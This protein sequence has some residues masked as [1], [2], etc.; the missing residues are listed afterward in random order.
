MELALFYMPAASVLL[1]RVLWCFE[2]NKNECSADN[3]RH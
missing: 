1:I 3:H 2:C